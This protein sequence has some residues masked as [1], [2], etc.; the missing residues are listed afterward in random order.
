MLE[1]V[2]DFTTLLLRHPE[3]SHQLIDYQPS[4][5]LRWQIVI[6]AFLD[7]QHFSRVGQG[8]TLPPGASFK[9]DIKDESEWLHW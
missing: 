2:L 1:F 8:A 5:T 4:T 7:K 9:C 6:A 3:A